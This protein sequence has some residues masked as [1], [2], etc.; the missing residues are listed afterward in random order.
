M[1]AEM[2]AG[3]WKRSRGQPR[4]PGMLKYKYA[5]HKV[6]QEQIRL[7]ANGINMSL[8]GAAESLG[9]SLFTELDQLASFR[10]LDETEKL[11][12]IIEYINRPASR[13]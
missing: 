6:R 4:A 8:V 1:I 7:K 13:K 9:S 11:E 3:E 10:N 12:K 5:E 2:I